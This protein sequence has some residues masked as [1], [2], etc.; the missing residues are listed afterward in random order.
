[1]S[2][3]FKQAFTEG[4]SIGMGTIATQRTN[5]CLLHGLF[6]PKVRTR[7]PNQA[8]ATV[9]GGLINFRLDPRPATFGT[10]ASPKETYE[11]KP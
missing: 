3:D 6:G 10:L 9:Q 8:F 7:G 4:F 2:Y 5:I 11:R 1:M